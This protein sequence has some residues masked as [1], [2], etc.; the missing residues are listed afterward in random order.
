LRYEITQTLFIG[1]HTLIVEGGSD[2]LYVQAISAELRRLKRV[3]LDNRWTP[4][5]AGGVDKIAAFLSLFAGN[6]LHV[7]V[8]LDFAHGQ[9]NKVEALR[10][11]K[12]L[13]NGHV[14][15]TTDFCVQD[16]ADIEDLLGR[17]LYIALVNSTY[18]LEGTNRITDEMCQKSGESSPRIIKQIE[19]VFR[20]QSNLPEFDHFA[21]SM[22]LIQ[23][24]EFLQST[25]IPATQA[26]DAFEKLFKRLNMLL[27]KK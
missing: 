11:S 18:G 24:P 6:K 17:Q 7:A 13:G 2:I 5:P 15:A 26:L 4:C 16:E 1:E 8:L 25:A 22:W 9:K 10:K 19:A 27:P 23:H 14:F 3:G 21:P 12:L 20:V